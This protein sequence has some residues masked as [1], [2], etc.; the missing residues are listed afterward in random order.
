VICDGTMKLLYSSSINDGC[1]VVAM[2]DVVW[3]MGAG[4]LKLVTD[5]GGFRSHPM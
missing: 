2:S 4:C 5:D 3:V 1:W